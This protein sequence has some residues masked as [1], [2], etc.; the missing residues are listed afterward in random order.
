VFEVKVREVAKAILPELDDDFAKTLGAES[1]A[2]LRELVAARIRAEYAEIGRMKLK[3]QVLDALDK[4]HD[5]VL[6]ETLVGNEFDA[7]WQQVTQSLERAGKSFPQEGKSEE[8]TKAEYR[9]IAERRVRLGLVIGEIGDKTKVEISEEEMRRA[10]I[11]EA[12]RYPGRQRQV[13]EFYQKNPGALVNLRAPIFEDKVV[14]HIVTQAKPAEKK[15]TAEE[16]L[17]PVEGGDELAH[18]GHEHG[19][20]HAHDHHDHDHGHDHG[21]DHAHGHHDHDHG[22]EHGHDHGHDHPEHG[23]APEKK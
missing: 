1:L 12:N 14:E 22:H 2:K 20:D 17:K 4:A 16:L 5:F 13:Y 6:P 21:H 9:K 19:H 11:E 23:P 10:L 15:V 7:I 8:E 18:A 3:Q